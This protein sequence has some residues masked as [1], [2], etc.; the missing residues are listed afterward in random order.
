MKPLLVLAA[1]LPI[2]LTACTSI[3]VKP[4]D[5]SLSISR[6]CIEKNE[7]VIVPQFLEIVR[8]GFVRHGIATELYE[9]KPPESCTV[10]L[11]YTALRKWDFVTYLSHAELWLRDQNGK[12]LAY[13]EYHLDGGGGFDFSKWDSTEA[14]MNPV[15]DQL[16]SGYE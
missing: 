11:T 7:K 6:I 13:A 5:G 8:A 10:I 15:I 4:L 9:S 3:Q 14:K 12:Q 16:L 2:L 1:V